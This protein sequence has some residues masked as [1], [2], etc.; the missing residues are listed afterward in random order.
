MD[1]FQQSSKEM[2]AEGGVQKVVASA[3]G[4]EPVMTRATRPRVLALQEL[5]QGGIV[6]L[7]TFFS[8]PHEVGGFSGRFHTLPKMSE[9]GVKG[10]I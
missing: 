1:C 2:A 10:R 5:Y 4:S 6:L 3:V 7:G 9:V 8:K